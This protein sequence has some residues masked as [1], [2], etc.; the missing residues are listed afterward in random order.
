MKDEDTYKTVVAAFKDKLQAMDQVTPGAVKTAIKS[1][2]KETKLKG[3][4]VFMPIRVAITGQMH[5]AD[6][7]YIVTLFGKDKTAARLEAALA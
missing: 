5:G 2:M 4:F 7:N 3:K 1:I 6:L